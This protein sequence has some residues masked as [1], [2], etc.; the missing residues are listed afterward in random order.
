MKTFSHFL[1]CL[2]AFSPLL[3]TAA[4]APP[5]AST[6]AP[7]TQ[8]LTVVTLNLYH[9]RED[10]PR[11]R[12]Q[13]LETFKRLR[14]DVIALQEVIQREGQQNQAQW[15]A[16][17]LGYQWRFASTDP[18]GSPMR[19]GNALLTR[20]RV[21]GEGE[22]RLRPLEDHRTAA[23][24]RLDVGGQ[25]LDV[26]VTHLFWE[27]TTAGAAMRQQ[28]LA[29]LLDW[30]A[31][32]SV[33]VPVLL[34]GD[35]NASSEA[36]ELAALNAG[37]DDSYRAV[38]PG[39]D[40]ASDSTLDPASAPPMR[41]DHLFAQRGRFQVLASERL[42]QQRQDGVRA[43][44]HYGVLTTLRALPPE[45]TA[46]PWRDRALSPDRRAALLVSAMTQDEKFVMIRSYFGIGDKRPPL[47][48]GSAGYV[49]AIERLGMPAQ[50]LADAG[51][52]VTNPGGMRSGD[53][54][55]AMPSGLATASSWN[56]ALAFEGGRTMGRESWQQGFN[57]LLAGSVNLQRDPRNG[58]NFEYAGEDPLLAGRIVG[59]SIRGVQSAHVV[60]TMKHYALNDLETARNFHSA[61]IGEQAMRESDLLAF[62][63]ALAIGEPG[64]VMCSYNRINGTYG[65]EHDELLNR[66]LKQQWRWP[67]YVM[68]DWGGVHS[69]SKAALAGL[70][71][72]SAGEVFDKAVYFDA[73]LRMAVSAGVVPQARLDDMVRRIARAFFAT[74]AFDHPPQR[75]P[76]EAQ[77][78]LRAARQVATEG[79]VLLRNENAALPIA[80]DVQRIA[81]IGGH[82]DKGVIGGGGSSMVGW[83]ALGTNAV[84][85]LAPTTWPG[86]VMFHPSSPLQ[87]L[88]ERFP[89]ARIDYV[90]G[91]DRAAAARLARAAQ[92]AVVFATQWAAESVDLPDMRLP[93]GQDA[94][95]EA[96]ADANPRTVVVLETNGP[97]R[98]PWLS[99]V[100]A[101]LQAWF[102][103]IGGGPAIAD[104]LSGQANPSGHLPVTWP[105]DETQLP[106][107]HINGLGFKPAHAPDDAID[108]DIEGA[109]VG[110][111]W[112]DAHGLRPQ[113]AFGH[114]LS[115]TTFAF[116]QLSLV[117]QGTRVFASF[118]VRNTGARAGAAVPQLYVRLPGQA[119]NRLRLAGWRR[120]ELQPGEVRRLEVELEPRTL[121]RFDVDAQRWQIDAGRYQV[122]LARAAD[123]PSDQA[124]LDLPAITLAIDCPDARACT[125]PAP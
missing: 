55:T 10:W 36:P 86:P 119:P 19:Y 66:I 9:D 20:H 31:R 85:G 26:Y 15:L 33:G 62:E 103:G 110:Y 1:G 95:I 34:A 89:Q 123:T 11:R 35:F 99:K 38:H 37:F 30:V 83:T 80:A 14:P 90:D 124:T 29:D 58:R 104:L 23:R 121:A 7:A 60:S 45:T 44:D 67:G 106:R 107:P 49:P 105:V 78:G 111:K 98:L 6:Q 116:G 112:F 27:Q 16:D 52:G 91:T 115:Y 87:A 28:Q 68:S 93:D 17:A 84:P 72:Q 70:D 12:V 97:V 79:S 100:P 73:P 71:Q 74:G 88:R 39:R 24:V 102:P 109:Q 76:I 113:F 5:A 54:S 40:R 61:N 53:V 122:T 42:F 3:A 51:L 96:V 56:R 25:A 82:A 22:Q 125:A 117:Q 57:V 65:C 75:G 64:S 59:E 92:V 21:L 108:Y 69:G 101:V 4:D 81:V 114:G 63:F 120:V 47:S 43:S 13:I 46:Q 48:L 41:I 18:A 118:D 77:A 32:D 8:P 94:L 50:Q 2:L